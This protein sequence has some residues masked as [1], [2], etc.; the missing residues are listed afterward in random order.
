MKCVNDN[1]NKNSDQEKGHWFNDFW[2]CKQ[3]EIEYQEMKRA[4]AIKVQAKRKRE[5]EALS[6]AID[7]ARWG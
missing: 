1:C 6:Y 7:E 5:E 4:N 2:S 3:C